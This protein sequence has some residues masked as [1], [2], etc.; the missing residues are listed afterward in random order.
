MSNVVFTIQ[1]VTNVIGVCC[2]LGGILMIIIGTLMKLIGET[3]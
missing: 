2:G 3:L 1:K